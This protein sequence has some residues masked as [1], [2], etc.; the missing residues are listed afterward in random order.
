MTDLVIDDT[1][2]AGI[3]L[4]GRDGNK[5]RVEVDLW[6]VQAALIDL[7]KTSREAYPTKEEHAEFHK[8]FYGALIAYL[9]SL[10]YPEVR[11]FT[12]DRFYDTVMEA[13][14]NLGKSP[15]VEP[16]PV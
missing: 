12:A 9:K 8:H 2:L 6:E 16:K 1:G 10:G 14:N 5:V 4:T 15:A 3:T 13:A 7:H 11:Q